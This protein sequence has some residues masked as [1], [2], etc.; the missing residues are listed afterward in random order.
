M[1]EGKTKNVG[2]IIPFVVS[3][4]I[5]DPDKLTMDELK[6]GLRYCLI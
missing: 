3:T 6:D 2:N 5:Q 1:K 4:N